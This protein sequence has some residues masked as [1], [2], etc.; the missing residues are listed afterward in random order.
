MADS[1]NHG[2]IVRMR[3]DPEPQQASVDLD[4]ECRA[5]ECLVEVWRTPARTMDRQNASQFSSSPSPKVGKRLFG[6]PIKLPGLGIPLDCLIEVRSFE[7]FEP[8]AKLLQLL[9]RQIGNSLL[10]I[11]ERRHEESSSAAMRS[12]I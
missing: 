11:F 7:L 6:E 10:D 4:G 1:S 9:A 12:Y 8:G 3:T 2:V 5:H